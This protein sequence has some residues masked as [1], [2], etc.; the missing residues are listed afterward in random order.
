MQFTERDVGILIDLQPPPSPGSEQQETEARRLRALLEGQ[1]RAE[2]AATGGD[3]GGGD[4]EADDGEALAGRLISGAEDA[5]ATVAEA[6]ELVEASGRIAHNLRR[7][8]RTVGQVERAVGAPR[9]ARRSGGRPRRR[10][11]RADKVSCL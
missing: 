4:D 9:A 3:G 1:T 10:R 11:R 5:D 2:R 8:V 6:E 7:M